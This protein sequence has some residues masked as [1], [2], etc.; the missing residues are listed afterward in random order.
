MANKDIHST[1]IVHANV[2]I[3]KGVSI[4]PYT[5]VDENV[6]L[7]DNVCIESH[8]VITGHTVLGE[9][10]K[11]FSG[12]VVGSD[13][14]DK[15]HREED[16]VYL[17][18]GKNN[19]IREFVTINPGTIEGGTKTVIGDRN[20]I[21]AY[22]HV[23]HD[24][25]IGNKCIMANAATL[26]GHV[27]LEDKAMIGGFGAIHQFVRIGK[28]AII[29]GCSKVVQDV[30][31]FSMCD[32]HPA[33]VMSINSVGLKRSETDS[34]VVRK[35]KQAFKILFRSG[36]AKKTAINKIREDIESC[37]EVDHLINFANN[38]KRGL[39]R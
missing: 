25:F 4:G 5:V 35:L 11:V 34:K 8:C 31:P 18:I 37:E 16:E 17:E 7:E 14:Q 9:G 27:T 13:P 36:L 22:C 32:G 1:A 19:V 21:M 10:T 12:A 29:G 23:A 2:K 3:G 30:P 33:K 28:L 6:V 26:A 15:K 24:C 38:S 20:L 39:S